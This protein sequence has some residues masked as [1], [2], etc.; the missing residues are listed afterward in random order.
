MRFYFVELLACPK[1]KSTSLKIHVLKE[2]TREVS[3]PVEK[4]RCRRFCGLYEKPASE[5]PIDE[6]SKCVRRVVVDGV[7]VCL[8]CNRWYPIIDTIPVMLTDKYRGG[9]ED[10]GFIKKYW[11][12]IPSDLKTLM[13]VPE[14]E[15]L[16][17]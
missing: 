10:R 3:S 15:S 17:S 6:C 7:I 8:N 14:P 11:S 5:V 16:L 9:S 12:T 2:E 1:C 4:L 13:K